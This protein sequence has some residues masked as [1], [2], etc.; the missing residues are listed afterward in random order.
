M[1]DGVAQG[2]SPFRVQRVQHRVAVDPV[3]FPEVKAILVTEGWTRL[4]HRMRSISL[5]EG[6]VVVVPNRALGVQ[7]MEVYDSG[8][9]A[10]WGMGC[11]VG[12]RTPT[13]EDRQYDGSV[14]RSP[15]RPHQTVVGVLR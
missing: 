11:S 6:D 8:V 9:D 7:L 13:Q 15:V 10:F 3:A 12:W 4:E 5:A 2:R 1:P 14:Y